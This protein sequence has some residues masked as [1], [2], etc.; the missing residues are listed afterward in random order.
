MSEIIITSQNLSRFS[1][2]LQKSVE[3]QLGQKITLT[4]AS[5]LLANTFGVDSIHHLQKKL[6]SSNTKEHLINNSSSEEADIIS[7]IEK[8]FNT[9]KSSKIFN[10]SFSMEYHKKCFNLS[11]KSLKYIDIEGFGIYFGEQADYLQKE[12]DRLELTKDDINFIN[13]LKNK[14]RLDNVPHSVYLGEKIHAI[15]GLKSIDDSYDFKMNHESNYKPISNY[16]LCEKLFVKVKES[17]FE[18]TGAPFNFGNDNYAFI[19]LSDE[20]NFTFYSTIEESMKNIDKNSIIIEFLTPINQSSTI[21]PKSIYKKQ[22]IASFFIFPSNGNLILSS[23]NTE[24]NQ[25]FKK[26]NDYYYFLGMK[27]F[28]EDSQQNIKHILPI[29]HP[30]KDDFINGFEFMLDEFKKYNQKFQKNKT[31]K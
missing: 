19:D 17:F 2:R 7:F 13:T 11:A 28:K 12:L 15:L 25:E 20:K 9:N 10:F 31:L 23:I 6:E 27:Q 22:G 24:I 1:K 30:Y 21:N 8:Y 29:N 4:Q 16:G 5:L 3:K 26:M 18:E 14:M